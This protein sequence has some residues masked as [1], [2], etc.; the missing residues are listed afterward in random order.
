[1][2]VGRV[3]E[4]EAQTDCSVHSGESEDPGRYRVHVRSGREP[5]A[6]T[7]LDSKAGARD[8]RECVAI[9]VT[10]AHCSRPRPV[11]PSLPASEAR[12]A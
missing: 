7:A 6:A 8:R 9:G 12:A 5:E 1:M 4:A 3:D 10:A 11:D 2:S